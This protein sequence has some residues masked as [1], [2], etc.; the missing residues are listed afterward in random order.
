MEL[1][2]H[3]Q[4]LL[5][6]ANSIDISLFAPREPVGDRNEVVGEVPD[7]AKRLWA[8]GRQYERLAA[9]YEVDARFA[10]SMKDENENGTEYHKASSKSVMLKN[11]AW[12]ICRQHYNLWGCLMDIRIGWVIIKLP[13]P[14]AH[15]LPFLTGGT[16]G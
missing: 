16:N 2:E 1:S 12:W 10:S 15:E 7:T 14:S 6:E 9:Q 11:V 5:L 13:M 8:L 3:L 4:A